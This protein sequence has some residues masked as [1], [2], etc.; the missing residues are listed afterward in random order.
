[1]IGPGVVIVTFSDII[2]F[3][4]GPTFWSIITFL[5]LVNLGL[6]TVIGII[7]GIIIPL[8][9]TFSSLREHSKLLTGTL[10]YDP[11][12]TYGHHLV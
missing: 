8:Q 11:T 2:S 10:T 7:Q 6:S 12:P 9:D 4:S 5:L 3:F 1:M